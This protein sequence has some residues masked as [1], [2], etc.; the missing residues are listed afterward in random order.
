MKPIKPNPITAFKGLFS[1]CLLLTFMFSHEIKAQ[2]FLGN[3][4]QSSAPSNYTQFWNQV[5]PENSGKWGS[6][7]PSRDNYNWGGLDNAYNFAKRNNMPF[8]GHTLVWGN[9]APNWIGNLS[10]SDQ[11]AEVEEWIRDYFAR[12]PDTDYIDVVNEPLHAPAGYRNALGGNGSTGWDWVV[13]SFEIARRYAPSGCKLLLNEY[14]IISDPNAA[15]RYMQ[16]VN[17]LNARGLIDGIGIQCHSF[18]MD[19]VS[20][21]TMNQV[22]GIL[23]NAGLPIYVSELD[24]RGNDSQQ[25]QRYQ[26]KFPIFWENPNVAGVTLWGYIQGTM[27]ESEAWLVTQGGGQR[28]AMQWLMNYVDNNDGGGDGGG[29]GANTIVVRARGTA[30][31]E[32][33]N[34]RVNNTIVGSYTLGTS[35][36]NY[37]TNTDASGTVSV[38]FDN[39]ADGRDVQVDYIQFN[40][41]TRQSEDQES[42][43]G[44]YQNSAC[45][46]S[47]S[48][49]LH[50]NGAITY[51]GGSGGG[52]T[53]ISVRALGTA[54]SEH[55]NLLVNNQVVA[56]WTLSTSYQT[57]TTSTTASGEVRV[58]FDND[59]DG[60][61][62]Q[63]DY[64]QV[65]STVLQAE[66]QATN[67]GVYQNSSCGGS[68]SEWLHCNGYISFGASA[69]SART[70]ASDIVK[71]DN[72]V[73]KIYPNPANDILH[74][75]FANKDGEK[76][77]LTIVDLNGSVLKVIPVISG[78]NAIDISSFKPGSYILKLTSKD[79]ITSWKLLKD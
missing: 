66:N 6:A 23:D 33:I 26:Q 55:I 79:E 64:I 9:Q 45:G 17:I 14:G 40:G 57:Y 71:E 8:K 18:N 4:Y 60:R 51:S 28:P 22:L 29:D 2:K 15:N 21:G 35:M 1:A 76:G 74:V 34:V 27:W 19:N 32:H 68:N 54:G 31:S 30:G 5:T 75:Q 25:L 52:G 58:Q 43:T 3:I 53:S 16:I 72:L 12:Y 39:D 10:Q 24:M 47:Y 50:C 62:V 67:T 78:D 65:N 73:T 42:N 44:V 46:G 63:V 59:A 41:T 20:T 7:E 61:D 49:W 48:E 38:Q 70:A 37:T 11:R 13:T 69:A 56:D 77:Q 36:Q